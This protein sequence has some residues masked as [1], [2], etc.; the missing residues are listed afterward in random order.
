MLSLLALLFLGQ[1]GLPGLPS[2]TVSPT[3]FVQNTVSS[4]TYY[5]DPT[6]NN[7][8]PCTSTGTDACATL[9][10]VI[11]KLP[12]FILN[13]VTINV[14][15]GTYTDNPA[16]N[17]NTVNAAITIAGPALATATPATGTATGTLTAVTLGVV[18]IL[19]DSAQA[20]TADDLIGTFITIGGVVRIVA[21]NTATTMTLASPFAANPVNGNAYTLQVPGAVITS[22]SSPAISIRLSGNITTTS[23]IT[24]IDFVS[25]S[26]SGT[27]CTIA[28]SAQNLTLTNSRCRQTVGSGGVALL[29]R[30]GGS[31]SV[32][33]SVVRGVSFGIGVTNGSVSTGSSLGLGPN[34]SLFHGA[35]AIYL[36]T[37]RVLAINGSSG[38]TAQTDTGTGIAI[39]LSSGSGRFGISA[40]ATPILRC[41]T[42]GTSQGIGRG[43][44]SSGVT[45]PADFMHD[46]LYIDGCATG[47]NL[48]EDLG[49]GLVALWKTGTLTCN[50]TTTCINVANGSRVRVP[51]TF[52]VTG[53]T[54][55]IIIDGVS[56]T[57]ANLTG[58]SP[59]RLPTTPNI[60][61]SS[62]WQ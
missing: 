16:F 59:T 34:N 25:T 8:G 30:G 14:A 51:A 12:L 2:R 24:G 13:T 38:W 31:L 15:A 46:N 32:S 27:G 29:Y 41:L 18:T 43:T 26:S 50:N 35:T 61:G 6:G 3:G 11:A 60:T 53:V 33:A 58:A 56:Y 36:D 49:N 44:S 28:L 21:T 54:T 37:T 47:I 55:D 7:N 5:V 42:L 62:V 40:A 23:T 4:S 10:G 17:D 19:T 1:S 45:V 57:K 52:T 22:T 39:R 20:W 9:T 48:S